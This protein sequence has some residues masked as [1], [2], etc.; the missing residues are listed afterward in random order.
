[1]IDNLIYFKYFIF[2]DNHC[3]FFIGELPG[4]GNFLGFLNLATSEI[5]FK[6]LSFSGL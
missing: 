2:D 6:H 3:C 1:M 5:D 4:V